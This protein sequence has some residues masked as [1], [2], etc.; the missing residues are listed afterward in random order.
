MQPPAVQDMDLLYQM[1]VP[2]EGVIAGQV[3]PVAH[4]LHKGVMEV[5]VVV[6]LEEKT[7]RGAVAV[8]VE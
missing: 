6:V 5:E 2:V 1:E 4:L 8:A 3:D 7:V